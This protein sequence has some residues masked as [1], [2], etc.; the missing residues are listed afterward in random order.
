MTQSVERVIKH[1]EKLGKMVTIE[2][3]VRAHH[4]TSG[5]DAYNVNDCDA[6]DLRR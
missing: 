1:L 5:N 2:Q 3:K 4:V 6:N